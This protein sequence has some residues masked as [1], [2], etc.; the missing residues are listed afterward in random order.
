[1]FNIIIDIHKYI[2][3]YGNSGVI[4]YHMILTLAVQQNI[5]FLN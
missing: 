3:T 4:L 2:L 1:M 5:D